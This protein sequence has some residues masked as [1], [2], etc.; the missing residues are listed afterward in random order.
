[1]SKTLLNGVNDVLKHVGLIGGEDQELQNL[2]DGARQTEIDIAIQCWNTL[3]IE[4]FQYIDE[5][6]PNEV[7]SS[8]ITLVN[9]T[10][11]YSLPED[12]VQ[13][14]WPLKD[15]TNGHRIYEYP[16]GWDQLFADQ[17]IPANYQGRSETAVIRP[18]D[19]KLLLEYTP[20]AAE[21]GLVFTLYYDKDQVISEYSD[22]MPFNDTV[23]ILLLDSV[24]E[25]WRYKMKGKANT[26]FYESKLAQASRLLNK[27]QMRKRWSAQRVKQP[28]NATDPFS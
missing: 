25:L 1:M 19:G 5:P 18:T 14:R 20:T 10:N 23:Y 22:A 28:A 15:E 8:T 3:I 11:A 26:K 12:L 9:G 17:H 4:L 13:I 27:K 6:M 16:G 24:V 7:G 21:D 2:N